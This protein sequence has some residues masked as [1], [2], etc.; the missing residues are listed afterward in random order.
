MGDGA[1]KRRDKS[2]QQRIKEAYLGI[3]H[4]GTENTSIFHGGSEIVEGFL[5]ISVR[6][7]REVESSD[8]H[9]SC[10]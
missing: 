4:D 1:W 9:P 7:V 8:V 10:E 3:K 5:V 6:S 2:K